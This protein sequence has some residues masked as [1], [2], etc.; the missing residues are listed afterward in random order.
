MAMDRTC[1]NDGPRLALHDGT[2]MGA[3]WK[4][5]ARKTQNHMENCGEG[6]IKA[7]L[8]IV[9]ASKDRRTGQNKMKAL[10]RGHMC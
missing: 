7:W 5:E 9:G 1:N 2:P 8:A 3:R 10:H 6:K 4:K